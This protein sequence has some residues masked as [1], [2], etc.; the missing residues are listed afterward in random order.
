MYR[1]ELHKLQFRSIG[2]IGSHSSTS[3]EVLLI[4]LVLY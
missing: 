3:K 4:F 1:N 2:S